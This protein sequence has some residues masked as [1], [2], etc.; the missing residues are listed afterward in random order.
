MGNYILQIKTK[1]SHLPQKSILSTM[2]WHALQL[3]WSPFPPKHFLT[4]ADDMTIE[5]IF[6]FWLF[7]SSQAESF[8][9]HFVPDS[10]SRQPR[11][12]FNSS[13]SRHC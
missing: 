5:L 13:L 6:R 11:N 2:A 1:R 12:T 9:I 8:Y 10:R 7:V 4:V 3:L